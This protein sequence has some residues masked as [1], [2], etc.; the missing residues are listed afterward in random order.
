MVLNMAETM[1]VS[2]ELGHQLI[3]EEVRSTTDGGWYRIAPTGKQAWMR[4]FSFYMMSI[5]CVVLILLALFLPDYLFDYSQRGD[6]FIGFFMK[7]IGWA[8]LILAFIAAVISARRMLVLYIQ[9]ELGKLT[10]G[11]YWQKPNFSYVVDISEI[12]RIEI[13]P[14]SGLFNK[15]ELVVSL[16]GISSVIADAFGDKTDLEVVQN[17][18]LKLH[19]SGGSSTNSEDSVV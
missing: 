15:L 10:M 7:F 11:S 12:Q 4:F 8:A 14:P 6:D 13:M 2:P 18:I 1:P 9:P 16:D 19:Q 17:W 5:G 3:I